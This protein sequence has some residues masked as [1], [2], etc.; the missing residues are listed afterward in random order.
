MRF[1]FLV[2]AAGLSL[3]APAA[4]EP[5]EAERARLEE[6]RKAA[7]EID[8]AAAT[9][10][11]RA[12]WQRAIDYA[13]T[14]YPAD[15]PVVASLESELSLA[16]YFDGDV[17]GAI[18]RL[19]RLLPLIAAGGAAYEGDVVDSQNAL[20]VM[21]MKTGRNEAAR[22]MAY[23]VL[24]QRRRQY[25]DSPD[26]RIV[27]KEMAAALNNVANAENETGNYDRAVDLILESAQV[28]DRLEGTVPNAAVWYANVPVYLSRAGRMEEAFAQARLNLEKV[29][30]ILPEGHGYVGAIYNTFAQMAAE[31]GQLGEA[32]MAGRRAVEIASAAFGPDHFQTAGY[33]AAL[34]RI[35]TAKGKPEEAL[36]LSTGTYGIIAETLGPEADISLLARR[37]RAEALFAAGDLPAALTEAEAV[38]TAHR[39][40]NEPGHRDRL[41]SGELVAAILARQGRAAEA[42]RT[43]FDVQAARRGVFPAD[44]LAR[45]AGEVRLGLL[46]ARAG[47]ADEAYALASAVRL[48][49]AAAI[50]ALGGALAA[51]DLRELR[52]ARGWAYEAAL[53]SG[54]EEAVF[55]AAQHLLDGGADRA[56]R[57]AR[58]RQADDVDGTRLRAA[59]DRI[60]ARQR[61]TRKYLRAVGDGA[62]PERLEDISA[63]LAALSGSPA[64]TLATETWTVTLDRIRSRLSDDEAVLLA[65]P[66]PETLGVMALTSGGSALHRAS[67]PER[68]VAMLTD[69]LRGAL[70]STGRL[71]GLLVSQDDPGTFDFAPGS[72]LHQALFPAKI[73]EAIGERTQLLVMAGG[74]LSR[75][76]F[77]V[78]A[79]APTTQRLEEAD[80]LVRRH[81]LATL[82][83]LSLLLEGAPPG[84]RQARRV[85]AIGAPEL[86]QNSALLRSAFEAGDGLSGLPALP[87]AQAELDAIAQAIDAKDRV[88]LVGQDAREE[89][90]AAALAVPADIVAFAT[91][92][93][94]DGELAGLTE[95]A[96]ALTPGEQSDGLLLA[97]EIAGMRLD[98]DW[99]ILSACNTAG[100]EYAGAS[101]LSGLASAFLYAGARN[102]LVSHWEVA[103]DVAARL[104][105]PAVRARYERGADPASGLREAQLSLMDGDDAR[106][107]HPAFWAP[108]VYVGAGR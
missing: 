25:A 105:V 107:R 89:D 78:L 72:A 74:P 92:G 53:D 19:E 39:S 37:A 3:A 38:Y 41:G 43:Y 28:A 36:G 100:P 51:T 63:Q 71:R 42:Y 2:L 86:G 31:R 73:R 61:L 59:Q 16:D 13:K 90:V 33:K 55:L 21:Y 94:L 20:V 56:V 67:L 23:R 68:E 75:L 70:G 88:L 85:I 60:Q 104:T 97:S 58:L 22:D 7:D 35:L 40:V 96:L 87:E 11:N 77:A 15:H 64:E 79:A 82:P 69:Q 1:I 26:E 46:A 12:G 103:D 99:V 24:D 93:L 4:A 91:H 14:L 29:S 45:L 66:G 95:P 76:P 81:A 9:E 62:P 47:V 5:T 101:G 65:V 106:Y 44:S 52:Q 84:S 98:A 17:A 50:Q 32:E 49:E 102:L 83:S 48:E 108:F 54:S 18:A 57:S 6:L 30:A 8:V 80:W 27:I 10:E 34:A